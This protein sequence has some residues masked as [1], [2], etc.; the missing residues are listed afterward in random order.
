MA[1]TEALRL[2]AR[3]MRMLARRERSRDEVRRRLAAEDVDPA[4]LEALLDEFEGRGWLSER[5]LAEQLV[6]QAQGRYGSRYVLDRLRALG[7]TGEPLEQ[8]ARSLQAQELDSARAVWRKRFGHPPA[9]L[10]EKGRQARFLAGRGFRAEVIARL[11][12]EA[13]D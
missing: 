10:R 1:D 8:A 11:L 9:S 13:A 2:R 5:R 7:V 3:V 4:Y 6:R 12:A